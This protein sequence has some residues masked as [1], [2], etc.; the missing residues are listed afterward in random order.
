MLDLFWLAGQMGSTQSNGNADLASG[1]DPVSGAV[2]VGPHLAV[3]VRRAV[4]PPL[5]PDPAMG[6]EDV[7]Q[8]Q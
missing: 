4:W 1:L 6:G 2:V 5:G 7:P 8:T 3:G